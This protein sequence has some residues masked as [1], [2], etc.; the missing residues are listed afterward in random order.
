MILTDDEVNELRKSLP[1]VCRH[2][3]VIRA[4]EAAI[5]K[6][7]GEPVGVTNAP[8]SAAMDVELPLF[9]PLYRLPEIE[10]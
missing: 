5:I 2:Q 1:A 3:D 7:I 10:E 6:K 4:A 9:T 8:F